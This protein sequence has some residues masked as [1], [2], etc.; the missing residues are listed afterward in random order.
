MIENPMPYVPDDLFTRVDELM[1]GEVTSHRAS[2][3]PRSCPGVVIGVHSTSA[4]DPQIRQMSAPF[5]GHRSMRQGDS[6]R[7]HPVSRQARRCR[8]HRHFYA[9]RSLTP[10]GMIPLLRTIGCHPYSVLTESE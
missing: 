4:I 5:S 6:G 2:P 10:T 1:D 8:A 7:G 3:S 9:R